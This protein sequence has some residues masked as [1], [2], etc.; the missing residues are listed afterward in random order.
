MSYD[1]E[2]KAKPLSQSQEDILRENWSNKE[3]EKGRIKD[4]SLLW[5][6]NEGLKVM[7]KGRV[8]RG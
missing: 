1:L 3:Y 7:K 2:F 4:Q 8:W 5:Q 6:Q